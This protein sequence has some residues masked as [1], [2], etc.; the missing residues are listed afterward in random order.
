MATALQVYVNEDDAL[1]FWSVRAV[2]PGCRGFAIARRKTDSS[3]NKT[4]GFLLNRIGFAADAPPTPGAAVHAQPSTQWPFQRFSWTDHDANT[5]DTVSYQIVPII[6]DN[7]GAL[8]QLT[9]QASAWS[10]ERTLGA[11]SGSRF[12]PFFNRGFVISQFMSRY[13]AEKH[14]TPKQFKDGISDRDEQAIRT[15]LSGDLRLALLNELKTAADDDADAEIYAALFELADDELV[16]ALCTLGPRAHVVLA[17]GSITK[18]Q[19]ETAMQARRRDENADARAKLI[20]ASVDV[21]VHD[22]FTSPGPLAHNKFMVRTDQCGKPVTAWTGS[23]NWTPT[24]LCTQLN[25]GLLIKDPRI[26]AVYLEQWHRLRDAGS[27]FPRVLVNA[28]STAHTPAPPSKRAPSATIWYSRTTAKVDLAALADVVA[29]AKQG[30]LFLMFMP[31]GTGVLPDVMK[32]IGKSNL[33]VRGV[34]SELPKGRGDESAVNVNL[35]HGARQRDA[36]LDVIQPEGIAHPFAN[37]AAEVTHR[38]FLANI[39]HAIIHSKV[40]VIDPFSPNAIVVTGSHNFSQSA[41]KDNDENFVIIKGDRALAEAYTV[42]I[43]A[44]YDHYRWRAFLSQDQHPFNGLQDNDTWMA[45][46]LASSARDVQF[47]CGQN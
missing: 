3:G 25:N 28:N 7:T 23:T 14:L 8:V 17:N 1:L 24:G 45:P 41:S 10:P 19:N 36:T 47:F 4:E 39:G 38:Q 40:L 30:I 6:R 33:Y 34:V 31:G 43:I 35:V 13:L 20:A 27:A 32:R 12:E 11:P 9:E 16:D 29:A 18:G 37:F 2:I 26:A 46:K 22:R 15:F 42:N 44:A 21:A 5:G